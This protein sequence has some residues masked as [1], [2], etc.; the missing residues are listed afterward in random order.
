MGIWQKKLKNYLNILKFESESIIIEDQCAALPILAMAE[1]YPKLIVPVS[2][3][4]LAEAL[5][6]EM[7]LLSEEL[8]LDKKILFIPEC[9]R[10][11]MLMVESE[12]KRARA[13]DLALNGEFNIII[14]SV[15]ALCAPA[16]LPEITKNAAFE[17]K[18][19]M[20]VPIPE[21][22][23]R[24]VELDYD[25]EY[26]VVTAGEFARR[27]GIVDIYSP[28]HD[29]PCRIEYWGDEI[30]SL[31]Q[32]CP[33]T[34]RSTGKIDS[35]HIIG[36]A[37]VTAGGAAAGDIFHYFDA[38]K[39][40]ILA[41]HPDA[42]RDRLKRY[43]T[44]ENIERFDAVLKEFEQIGNL[45]QFVDTGSDEEF[46]D[47]AIR[48]I[49]VKVDLDIQ[50]DRQF[51]L[52]RENLLHQLDEYL[53]D[54]YEISILTPREE[55]I[56]RLKHFCKEHNFTSPRI[57]FETGA[58]HLSFAAGQI[59]HVILTETELVGI[60]LH[61]NDETDLEE[62]FAA[63]GKNAADSVPDFSLAELDEGDYAVHIDYGIG[64]YKGIKTFENNN[65]KREMIVIE[66]RDGQN[67][68]VPMLQANKISRYLG[69]PGKIKLHALN[70]AKWQRDK[71]NARA[72]VHAYAADMLRFQ[73]MRQT[74]SGLSFA[75]HPSQ[76]REFVNRF[77]FT[78]TADQRRS[79]GEV[80]KD[81]QS[82]RPMDRL[83]C[84]D[85][86][87]GKTEIAMR[88]A[89][90]AVANGYQVAVLAPTTVLA[91][92]HYY[93]FKERFAEYPFTVD[94]LSRFRSVKEQNAVIRQLAT[95]G[96][97]IV[98]GTHRLCGRE[99]QF[100][101]LG[102]VIIDEEQRFGVKHKEQL[103]HLRAEVDVL[104]MSATPIPRTLYLAMAGARDLSTLMTAPKLRLP[105][106]TVVAPEEQALVVNAVSA[107]LAR[108]GQIY[109]LHNR[110][111][112]I[113]DKKKELEALVPGC[114][115]A[116]AHGQMDEHELEKVMTEFIDKKIDCLISSTIIESG[117]DVPNAN[118]II[119]ER[120]DRFGLAELYQLRG[121]VGRWK[122][123]AYSYMLIPKSQIISSD[124]RKRLAAI[125]RCSNLG[126][127]FQLALRDLEIRGSGNILGS[128]QSG[129]LNLIGFDL[130]CLLLKQEVEALKGNSRSFTPDAE[131]NL[132]FVAYA[133]TAPAGMLCASFGKQ[134]IGGERLRIDTYRRAAKLTTLSEV[135][136]FAAELKDRFGKLP[137]AA[138]N[139]LAIIK[140]KILTSLH[141][142]ESLSVADGK[143][144]L[145]YRDGRFYKEHG[146][147]PIVSYRN[148]PLL[149]L[150]HLTEIIKRT[151]L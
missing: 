143:V 146:M 139:L 84:G 151:I 19:G 123:Q 27:G 25:D 126:A 9:A 63:G 131:I 108:G 14:G 104:T 101:N 76:V 78:D 95:G 79:T 114:R 2:D 93:N 144:Y 28:A 117:L 99:I 133:S 102:L 149:R 6:T 96:V 11:K 30:T 39:D 24:L 137:A 113:E 88:A 122:H 150:V 91:Q 128:E 98:I 46:F 52:R 85:V 112:S 106:K 75:P 138:E 17:I 80:L 29:Y 35:Y 90:L 115:F 49:E 73:A 124:A 34:Q 60:G 55:N 62:T 92:Q 121:R 22:L 127:G 125:K 103:R 61:H 21:L 48:S 87:Y 72:G 71:E 129:H 37:G 82:A 56:A 66:F 120:A 132:D 86:G 142:F 3:L 1:K 32:F 116:V 64:I 109:Y 100:K 147:L 16:P 148:P 107:E 26:E 43:G 67:L 51:Q 12:S 81:M 134:Y 5:A 4:N 140:I 110:V 23:K 57:G 145:K 94:L 70:S 74:V 53:S 69:S 118:T 13:L 38:A 15:H 18:V 97:D 42:L 8:A 45:L 54:G 31:R 68:Y 41:L 83:L 33:E 10:G 135:D 77:Q 47:P 119:I 20:E 136:D 59:R 111:K 105:V 130:Y 40:K 89:F 58:L 141:N 50:L 7:N 36:R 65:I 44:A